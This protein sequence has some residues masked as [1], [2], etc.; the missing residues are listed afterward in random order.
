MIGNRHKRFWIA[1]LPVLCCSIFFA[2]ASRSVGQTPAKTGK[3]LVKVVGIRNGDG[4][5]RVALRSD[6]NTV[7]D[8]RVVDIDAKTM[9]AEAVFENLPE[10]TYGVAVIHDENQNEKLDF[11]EM[12]M[13][14]EGYGYSNNPPKRPGPAPFDETKFVFT[15]P[16]ATIT[17]NL[18][19]WP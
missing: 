4:K 16:A 6:E 8:S 9:V 1:I 12:G 19:Y 7:V 18:I 13:P 15:G 10:S 2:L 14:I 5:I 3:L 11:N 17:V